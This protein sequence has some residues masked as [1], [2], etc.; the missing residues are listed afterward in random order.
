MN[1]KICHRIFM[2]ETKIVVE[3][4]TEYIPLT[5]HDHKNLLHLAYGLQ[6]AK[7][8]CYLQTFFDM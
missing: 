7:S 3:Q 4:G 8:D 5:L 6:A 2:K 1:L